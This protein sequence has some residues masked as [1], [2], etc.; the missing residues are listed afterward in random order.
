MFMT[1]LSTSFEMVSTPRYL[2]IETSAALSGGLDER[3]TG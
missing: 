1:A 2:V 3:E